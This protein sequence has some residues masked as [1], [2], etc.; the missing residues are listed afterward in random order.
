MQRAVTGLALL[1]A[2]L[3]HAPAAEACS[4]QP[5]TRS[6]A[7]RT[8]DV[9]F[10]GRVIAFDPPRACDG[11]REIAPPASQPGLACVFGRATDAAGCVPGPAIVAIE[12]SARSQL[13]L[14]ARPSSQ[15][16]E[17]VVATATTDELGRY[18]ICG[19]PPATYFVHVRAAAEPSSDVIAWDGGTVEVLHDG[20]VR[21]IDLWNR[22]RPVVE[23]AKLRVVESFKNADP[24][25]DRWVTYST[26]GAG[27]GFGAMLPEATYDVYARHVRGALWTELCDGTQQVQPDGRPLEPRGCAGCGVSRDAGGASILVAFVAALRRRSARRRV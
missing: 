1:G 3:V 7:L 26:D 2:L 25:I 6:Q 27:C 12:A 13:G 20:A 9:A 23:R 16:A 8:S 10:R 21:R 5:I 18:A 4:C 11:S 19:L 22:H 14:H 24:P 17:P 15:R